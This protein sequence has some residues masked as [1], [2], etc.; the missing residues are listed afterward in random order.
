[1]SGVDRRTVL[2]I[3]TGAALAVPRAAAASAAMRVHRDPSCGCCEAWID[4][5]RESGF[6]AE[7]IES[8]SMTQVKA[9]LG[10]PGALSSCHTAEIDG[11]VLEG[12]VPAAAIRRLLS[13]RPEG[14][15]L[16]VP[17]MPIGSPGMEVEGREPEAYDVLLFG[18]G[19]LRVFMSFRGASPV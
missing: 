10:V 17:G 2:A 6:R 8:A 12:H 7:V 11:Y 13:L 4:H 14:K 1:M 18:S 19:A 5:V 16:A 15:G 3:A 9:R